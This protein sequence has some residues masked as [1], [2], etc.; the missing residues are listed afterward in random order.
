M[1]FIDLFAGIGGFHLALTSLGHECVFASEKKDS[2]AK[3]YEKNF[4]IE[5]NRDITKVDLADIPYHDILCAGFPCQPFSK[6][7][8]QKGLEDERNGSL[9]DHIVA[10]LKHH[11]PSY[12]ILENVR[13]LESHDEGRTW[14]YIKDRLENEL[15]YQI[16]SRILSPHNFGIPQHRERF[17]IVGSLAGMEHFSWPEVIN[18]TTSIHDYLD[19]DLDNYE[20]LEP[21]KVCFFSSIPT[22]PLVLLSSNTPK[23]P[24]IVCHFFVLLSTFRCLHV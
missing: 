12:V 22:W 10:I 13:N 7:G 1:K 20:S 4:E 3:L 6:A 11:R 15:G 23:F 18:T 16:Q 5:P 17:F 21:E 8:S 14:T 19:Q 2:L 24:I 9:F